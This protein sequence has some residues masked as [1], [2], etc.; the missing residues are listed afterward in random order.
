M[1]KQLRTNKRQ[2]IKITRKIIF[3]IKIKI[4]ECN[5]GD[6]QIEVEV[7]KSCNNISFV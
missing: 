5:E 6:I 1:E 3:I 2:I 7:K 4:Q